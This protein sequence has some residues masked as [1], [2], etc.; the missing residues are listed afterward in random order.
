MKPSVYVQDGMARFD[1]R[2]DPFQRAIAVFK[3]RATGVVIVNFRVECD[4]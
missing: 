4:N 3:V 2:S 1:L